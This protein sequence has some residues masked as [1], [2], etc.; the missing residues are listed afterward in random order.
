MKKKINLDF[1]KKTG[2]ISN[3]TLV[4][5]GNR[6]RHSQKPK[7]MVKM[8]RMLWHEVRHKKPPTKNTEK[9]TRAIV[10]LGQQNLSPQN[11]QKLTPL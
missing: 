4:G 11:W 6:K 3:K 10:Q 5:L 1:I 9:R 2:K 7:Y 8:P